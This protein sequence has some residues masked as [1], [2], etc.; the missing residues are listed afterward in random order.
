MDREGAELV[1]SK[2]LRSG[3]LGLID[4][5]AIGVASTG[6]AYSI[7]ATLGLVAAAV[8]WQAP[9]VV[10]LAFV[11]ILFA[12]FGYDALNRAEPDA[13]TTFVWVSRAFGSSWGWMAGW[14]IIVADVLVMASLAQVAAQ[15][16]FALFGSHIGSD[17]G[18]PAVLAL[19]I[20]FILVL[21]WLTIRGI[22]LTARLQAALV[23]I[24]TALLVVFSVAALVRVY[25][26][27]APA[28]SHRP[29]WSWIDPTEISDPGHLITGI[30]L[31]VFIY[32][33]WDSVLSVNEETRDSA[34]TPGLAAILST[35]VLVSVYVLFT[36][37][38]QAFAGVGETGLG[39]ANPDNADDVVAALGHAVFGDSQWG[40]IA[41]SG[42]V[43]MVLTSATASTQTTILPTAR[44]AFAMSFHGAAPDV[45]GRAH[46]R[47][48]TPHVA[49]WAMGLA[50]AGLYLLMDLT[51]GVGLV[52][53]AVSACGVAIGF[54][55]GMTALASARLYSGTRLR[56]EHANAGRVDFRRVVLPL[57]GGIMLLAA[58]A[59]TA[60]ASFDPGFGEGSWRVP[61]TETEIGAVFLLGIGGLAAGV[62][63][64]LA[65]RSRYPLF[66]GAAF[67][68]RLPSDP[69]AV[70]PAVRD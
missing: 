56:P 6:P 48:A 22:G 62:P 27:S 64:L 7:A 14:A 8:A 55:Y 10:I 13:G 61:G 2:G 15:Y 69:G 20:A 35:L 44:T 21:T 50:S 19:G 5:I 45:F 37:A 70:A 40:K 31:M 18:H 43:L 41:V 30:M 23:V 46:P 65:A 17:P 34:R 68:R 66:R 53:D 9:V 59:W 60:V 49:T 51:G 39:L 3:A 26:G 24:E 58:A 57:L 47:F 12:A 11:P 29:E 28:G 63:L 33:G 36:V 52:L 67:E 42:L 4:A 25:A 38:A 54:Y 16:T 1:R 32:W